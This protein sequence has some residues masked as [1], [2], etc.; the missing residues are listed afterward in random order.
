MKI[1]P[2]AKG[3]CEKIDYIFLPLVVVRKRG[4]VSAG[5]I[6]GRRLC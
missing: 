1:L 5:S 6:G 4:A 2:L 3:R